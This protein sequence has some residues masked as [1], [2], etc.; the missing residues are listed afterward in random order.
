MLNNKLIL[1]TGADGFIGSHLTEEL[2]RITRHRLHQ[3][4]LFRWLWEFARLNGRLAQTENIRH[5][6]RSPMQ[7]LRGRVSLLSGKSY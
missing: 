7:R 4:N 6:P 2:I 1:V 3:M 5:H